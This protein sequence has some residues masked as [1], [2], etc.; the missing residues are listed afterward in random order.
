MDWWIDG[1]MDMDGCMYGSAYDFQDRQL[2]LQ[3]HLRHEFW[4]TKHRWRRANILARL[5]SR[6]FLL[7]FFLLLMHARQDMMCFTKR[8]M[9]DVYSLS[10][11]QWFRGG[12]GEGGKRGG[13]RR[14]GE[15]RRSVYRR[16]ATGNNA[17]LF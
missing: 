1:W 4:F 6:L 10:L 2:A 17:Q 9:K 12:G 13:W 8:G 7:L 16:N 3:R 11:A 15:R 14:G 5:A